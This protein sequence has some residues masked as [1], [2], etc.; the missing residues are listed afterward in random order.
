[1]D[2][3]EALK[4]LKNGTVIGYRPHIDIRASDGSCAPWQPAQDALLADDWAGVVD[5]SRC[6][7]M[8]GRNCEPPSELC[9]EE[10]TEARHA[11]WTDPKGVQRFGHPAGEACSNPD[12]SDMSAS[13]VR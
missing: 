7:D 10:C 1:M 11:G 2:F 8:H 12:L 5:E 4:A 13:A 6:C 9:C 3:G